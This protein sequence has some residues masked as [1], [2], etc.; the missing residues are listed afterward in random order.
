MAPITAEGTKDFEKIALI[1]TGKS[2]L[3]AHPILSKYCIESEDG[4]T[5]ALSSLVPH[6]IALAFRFN[7]RNMKGDKHKREVK[8]RCMVCQFV[9]EYARLML[10]DSISVAQTKLR[11]DK[12]IRQKSQRRANMSLQRQANIYWND[13]ISTCILCE[14]LA[15]KIY[16]D[17]FKWKKCA[18]CK[19]WV[20]PYCDCQQYHLS[21]LATAL[22]TLEMGQSM[23]NQNAKLPK[24]CKQKLKR[25]KKVPLGP[26]MTN[27]ASAAKKKPSHHCSV[28]APTIVHPSNISIEKPNHTSKT[29]SRYPLTEREGVP[30]EE[31]IDFVH[32]LQESKSMIALSRLMDDLESQGYDFDGQSFEA[33]AVENE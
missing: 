32:Y 24:Q 27:L 19:G 10:L 22:G 25:V 33:I 12:L 29:V 20:C 1:V 11:R 17:E 18:E 5:K 26:T 21:H 31:R 8:L 14:R 23:K 15:M 30:S 4:F 7:R 9:R 13:R 28:I 6:P 16:T 2:T 3:S